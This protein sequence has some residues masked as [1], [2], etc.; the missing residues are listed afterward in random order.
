[1]ESHEGLAF[2]KDG[3]DGDK[4]IV[5]GMTLW[6]KFVCY[7]VIVLPKLVIGVLLAFYGSGFLLVSDGNESLILNTVGLTFI[8]QIDELIYFSMVPGNVKKCIDDLP[9]TDITYAHKMV[10]L[11]KPYFVSA[12]IAAITFAS[13]H[14]SCGGLAGAEPLAPSE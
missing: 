10:G 11:A 13:Y 5:S 12:V 9:T 2:A 7:V 3:A 14:V 8:T 1:M 4:K 6:F